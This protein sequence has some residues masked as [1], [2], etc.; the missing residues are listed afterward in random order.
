MKLSKE[1]FF[2]FLVDQ[3][4]RKPEIVKAI[5][6]QFDVKVMSIKTANFKE[7]VK[8]QR[9]GRGYF[10][11][12]GYK[13]AVVTLKK[14]QKIDLFSPAAEE[15]EVTVTTAEGEPVTQIK[16]KKSLLK[17]TKIK[18]EKVKTKKSK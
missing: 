5:E 10:T 11:L 7:Q 8:R 15:E 9:R 14:G 1:G 6:E 4:V 16:E 3:R 2:T 18:V 13:K 12:S 17:G